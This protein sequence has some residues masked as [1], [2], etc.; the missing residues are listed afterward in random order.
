MTRLIDTNKPFLYMIVNGDKKQRIAT[1]KTASA[2]Q[3]KAVYEILFNLS[4]V[5]L[6]PSTKKNLQ[7]HR[8]FLKKFH[9]RKPKTKSAIRLIKQSANKII[10]I[11][12]AVGQIIL[13]MT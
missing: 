8:L 5:P 11:M 10:K 4:I 2:E 9:K 13:N 6:D 7:K 1:F 12:D 3:L